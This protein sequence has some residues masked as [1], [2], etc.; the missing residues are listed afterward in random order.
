MITVVTHHDSEERWQLETNCSA[1]VVLLGLL[2]SRGV[3]VRK[4]RMT[5]AMGVPVRKSHSSFRWWCQIIVCVFLQLVSPWAMQQQLL[6]TPPTCT[7]ARILPS[8]QV[9]RPCVLRGKSA[10]SRWLGGNVKWVNFEKGGYRIGIWGWN[11]L[12][13]QKVTLLD[14]W[15]KSLILTAC[16]L[17]TLHFWHPSTA[18]IFI[19]IN[20][21]LLVTSCA[22][23]SIY[24]IV[25]RIRNWKIILLC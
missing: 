25:L 21:P 11:H 22:R 1:S 9:C 3:L 6:P 5:G 15:N 24:E 13:V 7:L 19:L 14:K 16:K 20:S 10:L 4:V 18:Q 8:K 17:W 2:D 12:L 23:T